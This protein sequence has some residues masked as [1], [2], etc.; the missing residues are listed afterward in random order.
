MKPTLKAVASQPSWV[1]RNGSVELAVTRLGGHMAPVVFY[2]D[3]S[4]PVQ[5]YYVSPWQDEGLKIDE[6]VLVPLRGDF[7]C[8]PFGA[9]AETFGGEKHR[10]HG[11]PAGARWTLEGVD[12][13]GATTALTLS[14]R[15]KVRPGTVTKRLAIVDAQNVVYSTHTLEGFTGAMPLGHHATLAMPGRERSVLVA[16][17]PIRFGMTN[18]VPQASPLE[19]EYNSLEPGCRFRRLDRVPLIWKSPDTGD[20]SRFPAREGFTDV[21]AVFARPARTPAWTAA[22]FTEQGFL[23]FSLKDA[24]VLPNTLLW[25]ANRGRQAPPWNGRNRCLGLEDV[26]GYFALG[27][28]R[29]ARPNDLAKAG[30]PTAVRLSPKEPTA[31]RYIQG[32]AKVPRGFGKVRTAKFGPCRVTFTDTAGKSVAVDVCHEFLAAGECCC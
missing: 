32:V 10:V 2:R 18:P 26:C 17:C 30:I 16:T 5:P 15:T 12:R 8:A 24:R 3:G 6:P 29:S 20:C 14:M 19:T 25:I 13:R 28:A 27:L 31:V 11:E 21:L 23:W 7:F 9:N 1:I 4:R 22:T